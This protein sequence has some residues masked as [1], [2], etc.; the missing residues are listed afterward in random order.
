MR[1]LLNSFKYAIYGIFH[2]LR[3]GGNVILHLMAMILVVILGFY[4]QVSRLEWGLLILCICLVMAAEAFNTAIEKLTDIVSPDFLEEA[5]KVK[6]L[7]AAA[8]LICAIGSAV[9]AALIFVPKFF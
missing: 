4:L 8:V 2:Y 7:A 6:D 1:R 5:G 9:I 3:T